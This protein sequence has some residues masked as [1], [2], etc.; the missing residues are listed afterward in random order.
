[1]I[2]KLMII[3]AIG[4]M[5]IAPVHVAKAQQTV[6]IPV[7]APSE[8]DPL[9]SGR[10]FLVKCGR[11]I[12]GEGP[13]EIWGI[14]FGFLDG[15]IARDGGLAPH[16]ICIPRG[17]NRAEIMGAT[18][19]RLAA[20]HSLQAMAGR[21]AVLLALAKAFPKNDQDPESCFRPWENTY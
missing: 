11:A 19:R 15:V 9:T 6:L 20:D 13:P 5:G 2:G 4:L 12:N 21:S 16:L 17:E 18:L 14:C 8:D 10:A 3:F 1:M 7:P